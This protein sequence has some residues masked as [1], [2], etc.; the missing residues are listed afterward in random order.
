[1]HGC[2]VEDHCNISTNATLNG[3][4][5][6]ESASFVGSSSVINGQLRVGTHSIVGS[7]A[8]VVKNVTPYTIVAGVPAKHIRNIK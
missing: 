7:G 4:V 6:V 5:I 8:V 2:I 1:E 3:D